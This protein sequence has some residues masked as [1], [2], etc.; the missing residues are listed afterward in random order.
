MAL[1]LADMMGGCWSLASCFLLGE[2]AGRVESQ[3]PQPRSRQVFTEGERGQRL[4]MNLNS[5]WITQ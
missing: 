3:R 5:K 4:N 2:I 1:S